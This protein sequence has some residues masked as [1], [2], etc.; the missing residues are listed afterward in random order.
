M[1]DRDQPG[2]QEEDMLGTDGEDVATGMDIVY[3]MH[4]LEEVAYYKKEGK[5]LDHNTVESRMVSYATMSLS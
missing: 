1:E 3:W 5:D 2:S 4:N